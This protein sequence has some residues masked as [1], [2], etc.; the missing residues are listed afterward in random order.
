[1]KTLSLLVIFLVIGLLAGAI[2]TKYRDAIETE[3]LKSKY[4][5]AYQVII[6][7]YE[8]QLFYWQGLARASNCAKYNI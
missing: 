6:M 1:M 8:T 3:I 7:H 2:Y 5:D 4:V